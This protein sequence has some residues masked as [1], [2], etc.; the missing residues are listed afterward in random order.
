MYKK[1]LMCCDSIWD[2]SNGKPKKRRTIT[3]DES[4]KNFN[5]N[6]RKDSGLFRGFKIITKKGLEAIDARFYRT[7]A[8]V[9]CALWIHCGDIFTSGTGCAGGY[10]YD[11]T[12]AALSEAIRHAGVDNFPSF[13]GSGQNADALRLLARILGLK[14]YIL[15][16]F[17]A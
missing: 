9:Y 1:T 13:A 6:Y 3:I 15:T 4:K 8:R 7:N 16:E 17:Y 2:K 5:V 10:G 14:N 11:R 12:S